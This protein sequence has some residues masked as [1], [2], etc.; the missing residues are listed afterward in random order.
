MPTLASPP[1]FWTSY[2]CTYTICTLPYDLFYSMSGLWVSSMF[3]MYLWFIYFHWCVVFQYMNIVHF[4]YSFYCQRMFRVFWAIIIR[5][6]W[7][8][9]INHFIFLKILCD[10]KQG[11]IWLDSPCLGSLMQFH[12]DHWD[13]GHMKVARGWPSKVASNSWCWLIAGRSTEPSS[14]LLPRASPYGLTSLG[15]LREF[16]L[17]FFNNWQLRVP[18]MKDLLYKMEILPLCVFV[19]GYFFL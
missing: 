16:R 13:H 9:L 17:V 10:R 1:W 3:F 6:L 18:K 14:G 11:R 7:L 2:K 5:V 15:S 12:C 4:I 8:F 19:V